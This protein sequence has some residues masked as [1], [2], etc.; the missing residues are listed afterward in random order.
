MAGTDQAPA[1]TSGW[2]SGTR[3]GPFFWIGW[4]AFIVVAS[5]VSV[6]D[7]DRTTSLLSVT[8]STMPAWMFWV[9]GLSSVLALTALFPAVRILA[10]LTRPV[11]VAPWK[12]A[13]I[14]VPAAIAFWLLHCGGYTL[15][16][17]AI[18]PAFGA[19]Y[20]P[21]VDP[22]LSELWR[23]IASY[24]VLVGAIWAV[25]ELE[26]RATAAAA[27]RAATP[28][29]FEIKDGTHIIRAT[30]ENIQAAHSAGNYV[31]FQLVD[32]RKP[33]MRAT[34]AAIETR[35]AP[36]GFVR[37]HRSWLVNAASVAEIKPAGSGDFVLLLAGGAEAPLSRRYREA[38]DAE[39]VA[40]SGNETGE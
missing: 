24:V 31:E 36:H 34:L 32:G 29:V 5:L 27:V 17:L 19:P 12:I 14:Q 28:P 26:D 40:A 16:R 8:G 22:P 30:T 38:F 10:G 25:M 9:A 4:A 2:L 11:K 33:L 37:T 1:G 3:F 15:I 23:D 18:F 7:V 6:M 13:A 20:D 21:H 39:R 35:L